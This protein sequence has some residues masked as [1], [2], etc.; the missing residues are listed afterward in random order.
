MLPFL[1]NRFSFHRRFLASIVLSIWLFCVL[2]ISFHKPSDSVVPEP[3]SKAQSWKEASALLP[4]DLMLEPLALSLDRIPPLIH[5]SWESA[6]L[7]PHFLAWSRTWRQHHPAWKWVLWTDE[8]N[9]ALVKK[10]FPWFLD[11]YER[12]PS[13]ICRADVAR[14]MYM[15]VYGG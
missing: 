5:Q 9:L 11:T 12:L 1:P 13:K 7:P 8:D 15:F 2:N 6:S 4:R 3:P 14:N 10:H